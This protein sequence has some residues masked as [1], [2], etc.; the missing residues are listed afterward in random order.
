MQV[1]AVVVFKITQLLEQ[2]V[3]V[4]V[5]TAQITIRL[6]HLEQQTQVAVVAEVGMFQ[7]AE[8]AAQAGQALSSSPTQAHNV[9]QAAQSHQAVATLF[10]HLQHQALT[11]PNLIF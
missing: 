5:A 6:R 3:L 7:L 10:T 8:T 9:A 1:V 11:L 2:A 4:V